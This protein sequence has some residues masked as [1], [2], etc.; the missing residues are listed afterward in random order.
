MDPKSR[1]CSVK[2]FL[3]ISRYLCILPLK[4]DWGNVKIPIKWVIASATFCI[5]SFSILLQLVPFFVAC[6]EWYKS[7]DNRSTDKIIFGCYIWI[8]FIQRYLWQPMGFLKTKKIRSLLESMANLGLLG[9][10]SA[11]IFSP[12]FYILS[13]GSVINACTMVTVIEKDLENVFA[14]A[15]FKD[16][17]ILP[18][19]I[20][21]QV[22][23]TSITGQIIAHWTNIHCDAAFTVFV[24]IFIFFHRSIRK[25]L[26]Q[27]EFHL[28]RDHAVNCPYCDRKT[29]GRP[30]YKE[31]LTRLRQLLKILR[32]VNEVADQFIF[33]F[34]TS[35]ILILITAV[36]VL[37]VTLIRLSNVPA[38]EL[39]GVVVKQTAAMVVIVLCVILKIVILIEVGQDIKNAGDHFTSTLSEL[40]VVEMGNHPQFFGHSICP[41]IKELR[42]TVSLHT[43]EI[44]PSNFFSL[45]RK[46]ITTTIS[47]VVSFVI[48]FAQ[49]R[50]SERNA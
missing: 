7:P 46:L 41:L 20:L 3:I 37:F 32:D 22:T 5:I 38:G 21:I 23:G 44:H 12:Q 14:S 30:Y 17:K 29:F 45:D 36:H 50:E 31:P 10:E 42:Q 4:L 48:V 35:S 19:N 8:F 24:S 34:V 28:L 2:V 9:K 13:I 1:T 6:S 26:G 43:F 15:D 27:L 25:A 18:L 33:I 40:G 47:T 39:Q 11:S 49:L 16:W